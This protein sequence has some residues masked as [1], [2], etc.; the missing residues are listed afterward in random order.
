MGRFETQNIPRLKNAVQYSYSKGLA[1]PLLVEKYCFQYIFKIGNNYSSVYS[2]WSPILIE[3]FCTAKKEE[4]KTKS[5]KI[6]KSLSDRSGFPLEMFRTHRSWSQRGSTFSTFI[7]TAEQRSCQT[8]VQRA[9][10]QLELFPQNST[11]LQTLSIAEGFFFTF[12]NLFLKLQVFE[13]V[14]RASKDSDQNPNPNK[15]RFKC[16]IL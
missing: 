7:S 10:V 11:E 9:D 3:L 2:T 14:V 15:K 5:Q 6:K 8:S 4:V 1:L 16:N 13:G 12:K